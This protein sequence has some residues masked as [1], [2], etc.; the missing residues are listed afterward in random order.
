M[1]IYKNIQRYTYNPDTWAWGKVV[2]FN[3][4][5]T[6]IFDGMIGLIASG[7]YDTSVAGMS[8]SMNRSK[9]VDYPVDVVKAGAKLFVQKPREGKVTIKAYT[10]EFTVSNSVSIV[11]AF[12]N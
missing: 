6:P 4:E 8:F 7:E 5:G 9:V 12:L 11:F 10:N 1:N 3:E 2:S